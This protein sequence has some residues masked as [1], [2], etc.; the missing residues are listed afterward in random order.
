MRWSLQVFMAAFLAAGFAT[1][2]HAL[3]SSYPYTLTNGQ[4]ADA[5]Q[6]MADFNCAALTSGSTLD[7]ITVTGTATFSGAISSTA[8]STSFASTA[9]TGYQYANLGSNTAGVGSGMVMISPAAGNPGVGLRRTTGNALAFDFYNAGWAQKAL[10][11][12]SGNLTIAGTYS[13]SDLRL[14]TDVAA[15]DGD[16]GLTFINKMRPVS[17]RWIDKSRGEGV[18]WGL[19]AQ[20]VRQISPRLVINSGE[21]SPMTPDGMLAINYAGLITPMVLAIQ[22]LDA[23]TRQLQSGDDV[24][25]RQR[26][27]TLED[28]NK[29]EGVEIV[30]LRAEIETI[31]KR[32]DTKLA[33]N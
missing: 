3:C 6:V 4:P 14:K 12:Q 23:R 29:R 2:A 25:L 31:E 33:R 7:T 28:D 20:E 11:D 17:Y 19:I 21:A 22:Q 16:A 26:I 30:R 32:I 9:N 8:T 5:S 1:E 13:P 18:Q 24:A 27:K 15:L 10:L